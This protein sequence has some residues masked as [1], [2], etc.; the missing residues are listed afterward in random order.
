MGRALALPAA[1]VAARRPRADDRQL[2]AAAQNSFAAGGRATG[3]GRARNQ[4]ALLLLLAE[5]AEGRPRE[6]ADGD[7]GPRARRLERFRV[8]DRGGAEGAGSGYELCS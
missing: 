2:S 3:R 8:H 7:R 1:S 4:S 6:G 5:H